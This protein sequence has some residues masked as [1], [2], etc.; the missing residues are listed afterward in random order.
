MW[1]A[2]LGRRGCVVGLVHSVGRR[3]GKLKGAMWVRIHRLLHVHSMEWISG[4]GVNTFCSYT[5]FGLLY[6]KEKTLMCTLC[7]VYTCVASKTNAGYSSY[8]KIQ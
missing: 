4:E 6:D 5:K 3:I 7:K 1:D 8:D 2:G